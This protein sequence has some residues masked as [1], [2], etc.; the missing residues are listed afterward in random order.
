MLTGRIRPA[1]DGAL[2]AET[3]FAFEKQFFTFSAA[4]AA[5]RV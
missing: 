5:L 2:V 4:L 1:L 3:F